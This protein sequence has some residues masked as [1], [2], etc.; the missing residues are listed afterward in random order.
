MTCCI[1]ICAIMSRALMGLVVSE[2][3][4]LLFHDSGF[5]SYANKTKILKSC[6][7]NPFMPNVISLSY[8][9]DQSISVLRVVGWYFS[10]LFNFR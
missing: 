6:F 4:L 5:I 1:Q 3:K 2:C 9:L 10:L 7:F 8:Q